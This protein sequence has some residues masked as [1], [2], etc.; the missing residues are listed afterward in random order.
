MKESYIY[1]PVPSRRLG[2]S[3]GVDIIPFKVCS[4]DCVYCQLGPTTKKTTESK[5]YFPEQEIISQIKKRIETSS[6]IDYITF[7]G[8]GEPTLNSKIGTLI[9]KIKKITDIPVAVLT[10]STLLTKKNV[11]A[12]L[13]QADLVVPSLDAAT[14]DVF[15]KIN[16]P[17]ASLKIEDIIEGLKQF[18][19]EFKG[20]LW[21]EIIL[22][23]GMN[24]SEAHVK[25]LKKAI[26]EI[27]PDVVQLNTVIRPPSEK[28]A[29]PLSK[30][31]MEKIRDFI[32]SHCEIVA[33]FNRKG[34]TPEEENLKDI[35]LDMIRRRPVTVEDI[36]DSLGRHKN[37]ILKYIDMLKRENKI[38]AV[39]YE[40]KDYYE[41]K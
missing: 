31:E 29:K 16:R 20:D 17:H 6:R 1:G 14:Q 2:L 39:A 38:K 37:E 10:N 9:K 8:S 4:L 11:R 25:A 26:H 41:P 7:S 15:E 13:K 22:V 36:S 5:D 23:K 12:S 33:H 28:S 19:K 35:I 30:K 32:G 18:R 27:K 21:L 40:N 34:L 24:D 3:L